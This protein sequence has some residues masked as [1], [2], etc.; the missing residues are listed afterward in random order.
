MVATPL[1][2]T[3]PTEPVDTESLGTYPLED[4]LSH[5]P[6]QMEWVDGNLVEKTGMTV[7]HSS[8]QGRL[9]TRWNS[10]IA[11]NSQ[12]GEA[13]PEAPC[14]TLKQVRRPDVA[15]IPA[16]LMVLVEQ[17]TV[18]PQT[19]PLIAEVASPDDSA[20]ELFA[21]ALEYVEAG[22]QEVWLLFP[23]GK[24]ILVRT[25]Q[26]W[27]LFNSGEN[28]ETQIILQGFR[29]AVDELLDYLSK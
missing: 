21:K 6:E 27:F 1:R 8:V 4:F 7:K 19:F 20:E 28:V 17:A 23:K 2:I 3:T 9:I 10:Y 15:Y 11:E 16:D 25:A 12:G 13:C 18:S 24:L 22:C 14:R 5:P 26:Q 29:V